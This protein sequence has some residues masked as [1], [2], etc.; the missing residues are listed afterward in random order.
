[1]QDL[2]CKECG[3]GFKSP[4]EL[5]DHTERLHGVGKKGGEPIVGYPPEESRR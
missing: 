4:K 5:E 2:K 1:M 3:Q